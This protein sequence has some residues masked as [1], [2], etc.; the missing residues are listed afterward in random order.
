MFLIFFLKDSIFS[1]ENYNNFHST[2]NL[3]KQILFDS[4]IF[5]I[6]I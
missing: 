3:I 6:Y 5:L 2:G 1:A 4:R